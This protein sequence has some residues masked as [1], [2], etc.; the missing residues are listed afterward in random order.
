MPRVRCPDADSARSPASPMQA[1]ALGVK[2]DVIWHSGKLRARQTAEAY[3]R[4]CNPLAP[5]SATRGLQPDDPPIWMRDQ[6]AGETRTIVVVGHMP[7]MP[8]LLR[9]LVTGDADAVD[10]QLSAARVRGARSGR[11][12][13]E[14]GLEV[15]TV[16]IDRRRSGCDAESISASVA[17]ASERPERSERVRNV[18]PAERDAAGAAPEVEVA[19]VDVEFVVFVGIARADGSSEGRRGTRCDRS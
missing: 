15:G 19:E 5:F 4:A 6:L 8:R 2:P 12:S 11:R 7:H 10:V 16:T 9:L 17:S 3:W 14:G 18:L 13:M 1:A